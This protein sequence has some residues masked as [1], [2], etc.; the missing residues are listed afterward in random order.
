MT[1]S[2]PVLTPEE[3]PAGSGSTFFLL[4]ISFYQE[5]NGVQYSL[6]NEDYNVLT[7]LDII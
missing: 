7:I 4:L 3:F 6:K 2:S 5:I 1:V